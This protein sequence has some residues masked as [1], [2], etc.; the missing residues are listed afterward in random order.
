[1]GVG[2]ALRPAA[3]EEFERLTEIWKAAVEATHDFISADEIAGYESRMADEFLPAVDL[4]VATHERGSVV[5][6]VGIDGSTI[7]MLFVDPASHGMGIGRMLIEAVRISGQ[8]MRVDVNEE[9][10]GAIAFYRKMGFEPV[11]RSRQDADGA[12]HPLIHMS[13]TADRCLR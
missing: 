12:E 10:A 3:P 6:F 9:N 7:E 11:G 13:L 2:L 8:A 4:T 5:G 1:M